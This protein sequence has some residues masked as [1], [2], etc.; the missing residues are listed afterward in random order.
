MIKRILLAGLVGLLFFSLFSNL[1]PAL[2]GQQ[3]QAQ[4]GPQHLQTTASD[5][6]DVSS[7]EDLDSLGLSFGGSQSSLVLELNGP[8]PSRITFGLNRLLVRQ[9]RPGQDKTISAEY[10]AEGLSGRAYRL[11]AGES[12]PS[13]CGET[14]R[15]TFSFTPPNTQPSVNGYAQNWRS[16]DLNGKQLE[17]TVRLPLLNAATTSVSDDCLILVEAGLRLNTDD[18]PMFSLAGNQAS[19]SS[20]AG[21]SLYGRGGDDLEKAKTRWICYD[22]ADL[23]GGTRDKFGQIDAPPFSRSYIFVEPRSDKCGGRIL[24]DADQV[25]RGETR[26]DAEWQDFH[27]DCGKGQ[28]DE[29]K[30][31]KKT[32]SLK[33]ANG[34]NLVQRPQDGGDETLLVPADT[35]GQVNAADTGQFQGAPL[36]A[37]TAGTCEFNLS[38][39][40]LGWILCWIVKGISD[41]L[42]FI[43][44]KVYDYLTLEEEDYKQSFPATSGDFTF[45]DA[46][47]NI[48]NLMT[49]AVVATALFMVIS[50]ALDVGVFKNYTVKKYLPRL[51]AG[52]L[53]IQFSWVL[54]DF[55][56]QATNL[57]G[58]ILEALLFAAL[59]EAEGFGLDDILS[60]GYENLVAGAAGGLYLRQ[61]WMMLIPLGVTALG[62]FLV[63]FL[64]LIAR[65]YLIIF[66]LILAPLGLALWILPGNDKAWNF[67]A[68]SFLYLLLFYPIIKLTI[69]A[70][71]IFAYLILL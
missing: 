67:Y 19:E 25:D 46:W 37:G 4:R 15:V 71:K 17:A 39:L 51:V 57:T 12:R 13:L 10:L 27:D 29:S 21:M 50:T 18:T 61:Y 70:G 64:F 36:T 58:D 40:G 26:L 48:R 69:S 52:A 56:I 60:G 47:R 5:A 53:L 32:V 38:G 42:K 22:D 14:A 9:S 2:G 3:A 28:Y 1:F 6:V 31:S 62:A 49:F 24:V 7:I 8:N 35:G 54:G 55:L 68:K 34:S 20:C 41:S 33:I 44:E 45:K 59:P 66:C 30:R 63:G 16:F 65:K 23:A 11:N 43:E